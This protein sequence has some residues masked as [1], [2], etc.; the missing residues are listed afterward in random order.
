MATLLPFILSGVFGLLPTFLVFFDHGY[1]RL[2]H[3]SLPSL[4][5]KVSRRSGVI[6]TLSTLGRKTAASFDELVKPW[7]LW[8]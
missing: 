6:Q 2:D 3:P 7:G 1:W 8:S 4:F 5:F